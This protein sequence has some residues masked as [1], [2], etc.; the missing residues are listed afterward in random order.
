M[1]K[2]FRRQHQKGNVIPL[3]L[4]TLWSAITQAL[5]LTAADSEAVSC[6][7]KKEDPLYEDVPVREEKEDEGEGG[8]SSRPLPKPP[9]DSKDS[10]IETDRDVS[11]G[12]DSDSVDAMTT[13]F[14][15]ILSNKKRT[16]K[17]VNPSAPPYASL[18]P[19]AADKVEV[20]GESQWFWK[21]GTKYILGNAY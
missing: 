21:Y 17:A 16:S 1:Q 8:A 13:S 3:R 11:S 4:W 10:S 2:E 5:K 14:R 15:K 9:D 20:G 6:S 12:E 7:L 19:V 18:F